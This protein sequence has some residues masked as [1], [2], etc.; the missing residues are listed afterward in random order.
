MDD[1]HYTADWNQHTGVLALLQAFDDPFVPELYT[2]ILDRIKRLESPG[3]IVSLRALLDHPDSD[4]RLR[5]GEVLLELDAEQYLPLVLGL[6][7]DDEP[8]VRH[9]IT[10]RLSEFGD[11]RAVEALCSILLHE[12]DSTCRMYAV[13][14]LKKIGD[15]RALPVLEHVA[16][17]DAGEDFEGR[18]IAR[19]AE[20]AIWRI[21]TPELLPPP[22]VPGYT[23]EDLP[24]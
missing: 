4:I 14:A 23:D 11:A 3:T 2:V 1:N 18:S 13:V 5:A 19:A 9:V 12:P 24:W 7:K 20:H 21:T 15:V 22:C 10:S 6:L 16:Q 8:S 17:H